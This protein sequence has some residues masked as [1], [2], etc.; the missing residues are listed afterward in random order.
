MKHPSELFSD[1]QSRINDLLKN[2]PT[3]EVERNVKAILS[4]GFSK[5]DLVTYKEFE[6]QNQVLARTRTRLEQ[7]EERV[8]DL[9][10]NFPSTKSCCV[11]S[12]DGSTLV[13]DNGSETD[14]PN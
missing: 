4:Q 8:A 7:L 12:D 14:Q 2:S 1:L 11:V 5:L 3:I 9:E 6:I 10:R 13:S